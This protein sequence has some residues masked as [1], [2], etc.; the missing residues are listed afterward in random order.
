MKNKKRASVGLATVVKWIIVLVVLIII[1]STFVS[2][3]RRTY[4]A[5][6]HLIKKEYRQFE[7]FDGSYF[8]PDVFKQDLS[9]FWISS[10][11]NFIQEA[12]MTR[13]SCLGSFYINHRMDMQD[14]T[15]RFLQTDNGIEMMLQD[16]DGVV[17]VFDN[18]TFKNNEYKTWK[19]CV[20]DPEKTDFN[21]FFNK[22]KTAFNANKN[23]SSVLGGSGSGI[24]LIYDLT[25]DF[26]GKPKGGD[27]KAAY[28]TD[29]TRE[30]QN[31]PPKKVNYHAYLVGDVGR[32]LG[33]EPGKLVDW[34]FTDKIE[35]YL[36]FFVVSK[37]PGSKDNYFCIV[38]TKRV[39]KDTEALDVN[40]LKDL[41][42]ERAKETHPRDID[43]AIALCPVAGSKSISLSAPE[44]GLQ[45]T[46][47]SVFNGYRSC[48]YYGCKEINDIDKELCE[49]VFGN[50]K[51]LC[52]PVLKKKPLSFPLSFEGEC[53]P[54]TKIKDCED[55]GIYSPICNTDLCELDCIYYEKE[56]KCIKKPANLGPVTG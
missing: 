31:E 18:D 40:K 42:K 3:G 10:F 26:K 6:L 43:N 47:P 51:G 36:F 15:I 11:K 33:I 28:F 25:I 22:F 34:M 8:H 7:Y 48:Y 2:I 4:K 9:T 54:C 53:K 16:S 1:L 20:V 19:L 39:G 23:L 13:D 24:T 41:F 52:S 5:G 12:S 17:A 50:C 56:N 29:K 49:E 45:A 37:N 44:E 14:T 30:E 27:I 38:P 55:Y 46:Y 32:F 21:T 35:R